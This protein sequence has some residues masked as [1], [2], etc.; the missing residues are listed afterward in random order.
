MIETR[1]QLA[2]LADTEGEY[3]EFNKRIVATQYEVLG[4]RMPALRGYAKRLVAH[5][6]IESYWEN[7]LD[8]ELVYEEVLLYGLALAVASRKMPIEKVFERLDRLIPHFDSWA[9]VDVVISSFKR[10][11]RHREEV[12]RH[13]LPLKTD[14]GEF[15]K[16]TFVILSMDLFMDGTYLEQTLQHLAEVEQ[17]QYYVDM[18]IAWAIS[19][20]LVK[21]YESTLPLIENP[22]FSKFVHNKAIQKARESYRITPDRKEYLNTLKIK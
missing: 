2:L 17:G 19:V 10:F 12:M 15:T 9:H 3:R 5:P 20:A 18:A 13:F 21:H 16:R 1:T 14:A 22:V 7:G 8:G 6:G 4:V 11:A